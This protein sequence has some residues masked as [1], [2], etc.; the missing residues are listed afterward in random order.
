VYRAKL[1]VEENRPV[2]RHTK[3]I[4]RKE[5]IPSLKRGKAFF[6][7]RTLQ[8]VQMGAVSACRDSH[9]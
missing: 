9:K 3:Q 6:V 4:R 5:E 7:F 2:E 1:C 8:V